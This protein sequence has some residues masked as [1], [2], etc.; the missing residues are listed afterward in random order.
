LNL[1]ACDVLYHLTK[2]LLS[3]YAKPDR[4]SSGAMPH[5]V[6]ICARQNGAGWLFDG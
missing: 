1:S 4:A 5:A 2:L 3:A 6:V